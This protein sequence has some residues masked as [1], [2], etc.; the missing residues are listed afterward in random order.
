[1]ES[2]DHTLASSKFIVELVITVVAALIKVIAS[3]TTFV[4]EN[5]TNTE[6]T[7]GFGQM[8]RTKN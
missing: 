1:L 7:R 4:V 2:L 3:V 6:Y 8:A 5:V